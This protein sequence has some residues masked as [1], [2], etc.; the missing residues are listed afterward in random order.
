M[1]KNPR[2]KSD[3]DLISAS[4]EG[5]EIYYSAPGKTEDDIRSTLGNCEIIA[6]SLGEIERISRIA[7]KNMVD[8]GIRINPDFSMDGHGG[9]P[10]KFGVDEEELL[11]FMKSSIPENIRI[12]GIHVHVKSQELD[13][14]KLAAYYRHLLALAGKVESVMGHGLD[15]INMGSGMGIA[16]SMDEKEIDMESLGKEM[17]GPLASFRRNH[18]G[19]KLLIETGRYVASQAG[20]YVTHVA[21]RKVSRGKTY[22]I[23][24]N[25]MNGFIRPSLAGLVERYSGK[26]PS[27]CEPLFSGIHAFSIEVPYQDRAKETVTLTGNLCTAA[28]VIAENIEIPKLHRG[29]IVIIHNAGAYGA[30]LSPMQFSSQ[31]MPDIYFLHEDGTISKSFAG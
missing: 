21:D 8:I 25:T 3:N 28:D 27:A 22:I 4:L 5:D 11:S 1:R 26:N 14:K 20:I 24:R 13:G 30:V 19:T 15:Y 2:I 9:G 23:L 12:H 16:Y 7:G 29:D 17:A 10:S 31:K 18:P 6:D